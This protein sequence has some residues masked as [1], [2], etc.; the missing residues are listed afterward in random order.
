MYKDITSYSQ[1]EKER[2][3]NILQNEVNGIVFKVH[4]HIYYGNQ[5]LLSCAELN[6]D[7][8]ELDTDDMET[9]K[10]KGITKM[11]E[12]LETRIVEYQKAIEILNQ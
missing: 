5:W 12:M 9:A 1:G 7:K 2:K 10:E 3:P 6:I 11:K 4:K 8:F